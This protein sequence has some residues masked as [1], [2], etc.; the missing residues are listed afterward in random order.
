VQQELVKYERL[1]AALTAIQ[2][3]QDRGGTAHYH[4]VDLTDADAVGRVMDEVRSIS[5]RVDVLLHAAGLEISRTLPDKQPR[6]YDLVFDVKSD[7]WFSVLTAAGDMPIGATV[8]FSSIAGRFGNAGQTDYSAANDLLCKITSSFR[9]TRRQTRGI[10]LDWT[11]WGGI[12]MAT[13]GSIPKIMEMAGIEMLPPE[14]GVAWIRRELTSSD[15]RGEVVVAGRLGILTAEFDPT[16]GLDPA[17]FDAVEPTGGLDPAA[18]D[19]V[20][21]GPM[22]GTV[23]AAGVH[24]G[25]VVRTELD[26]TRQPFLDHHRIDGTAVLPGVMGMEAFAEVARLLAPGRQVTT[27]CDVDFLAPVKFYRDEPRTLTISAVVRRDGSDLVADCRL[28]AERRLPGTDEPQHTTH[29]TGKVRLAAGLPGPEHDETPLKEAATAVCAAD[30]YAM[31]FHGPAYQVVAS[32]WR[33]DGG[34]AA[35]FADG[36]PA[37]HLPAELPTVTGPRL[38]ELCFQTAG[39]WQGGREGRLGLPQHVDA[40]RVLA[41]PAAAAGALH[42][43][44][45]PRGDVFDCVVVDEHGEVFIR[46]DGYRTVVLPGV[47]ADGVRAP[48]AAAMAD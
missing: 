16:G 18:F 30:V 23:T 5:G 31:Y 42:A 44:A 25:L 37:N 3:V 40:V 17:A 26:P 1:Q 14:A 41:D 38:V 47:L 9:R 2:A 7:G 22:I 8:A 11:A 10:V 39:L 21:A 45:H 6:E 33:Y 43:V 19:A 4:S 46:V 24:S 13:R 15:H 29:C 32:A 28:Q 34:C 48:L 27:V 35:R 12:G 20:E 36:L